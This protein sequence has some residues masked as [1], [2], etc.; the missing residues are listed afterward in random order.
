MLG[1]QE[2][3]NRCEGRKFSIT[4]ESDRDEIEKDL[5]SPKLPGRYKQSPYRRSEWQWPPRIAICDS[6]RAQNRLYC[7]QRLCMRP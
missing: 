6:D 7:K 1:V 4:K 3:N 5:T 2:W